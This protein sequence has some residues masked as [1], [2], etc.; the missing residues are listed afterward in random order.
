MP[1]QVRDALEQ[2]PKHILRSGSIEQHLPPLHLSQPPV[3]TAPTPLLT[4]KLPSSKRLR[5]ARS[6]VCGILAGVVMR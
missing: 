3:P 4:T 6:S 2:V 1:V 5:P